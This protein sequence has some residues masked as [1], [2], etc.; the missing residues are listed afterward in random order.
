MN[1]LEARVT[2]IEA[3]ANKHPDAT[4]RMINRLAIALAVAL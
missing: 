3:Q 1:K 4:R 2:K